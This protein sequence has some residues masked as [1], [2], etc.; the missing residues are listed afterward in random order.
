MHIWGWAWPGAFE[1]PGCDL[2]SAECEMIM[3]DHCDLNR[4]NFMG[5]KYLVMLCD[6][7]LGVGLARGI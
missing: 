5:T 2:I 3:G 1:G 4:A 7:C 6:V